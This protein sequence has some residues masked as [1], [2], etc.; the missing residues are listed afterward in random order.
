MWFLYPVK[1]TSWSSCYIVDF[2]SQVEQRIHVRPFIWRML[3]YCTVFQ[4]PGKATA[5]HSVCSLSA[6]RGDTPVANA[7]SCKRKGRI[8][9]FFVRIT[10]RPYV[11]WAWV[12][13]YSV[14]MIGGSLCPS[15]LV[16][17]TL[18]GK[19][20]NRD[21]GGNWWGFRWGELGKIANN[22]Q[23]RSLCCLKCFNPVPAVKK[24]PPC[25]FSAI[26]Y[27]VLYIIYIV[28][29]IIYSNQT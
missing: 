1:V 27:I 10:P 20:I 12:Q 18:L 13:K 3:L 22:K 25:I 7:S 8:A 2:L 14:Y 28:Y 6:G 9:L 16:V 4:S 19:C 23:K 21:T 5:I 17:V 15:W 24:C 29:N 26:L 11:A